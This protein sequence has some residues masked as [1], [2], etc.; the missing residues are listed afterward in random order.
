MSS[1]SLRA[2]LHT[3]GRRS[4]DIY[5][6][7]WKVLDLVCPHHM[8]VCP[9]YHVVCPHT[10]YHIVLDGGHKALCPPSFRAGCRAG[11]S[12]PPSLSS[13]KAASGSLL[14]QLSQRFRPASRSSLSTWVRGKFIQIQLKLKHPCMVEQWVSAHAPGAAGALRQSV[15]KLLPARRRRRMSVVSAGARSFVVPPCAAQTTPGDR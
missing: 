7:Q 1:G 10:R 4:Y 9:I 2:G 11:G 8:P 14:S 5:L 15:P 13:L 6:L 3:R 12:P